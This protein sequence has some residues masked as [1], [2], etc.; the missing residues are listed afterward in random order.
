MRGTWLTNNDV[1]GVDPSPANPTRALR[2]GASITGTFP[3]K[4]PVV[5]RL[6]YNRVLSAGEA[7]QLANYFAPIYN[8]AA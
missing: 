8:I 3:L 6:Y 1:A 4:G 2:F 5:Q 7:T